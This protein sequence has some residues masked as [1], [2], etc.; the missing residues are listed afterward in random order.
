MG[1]WGWVVLGKRK[2]VR[3]GI[4]G[5]PPYYINLTMLSNFKDLV[6]DAMFLIPTIE[7]HILLLLRIEVCEHKCAAVL[8]F[9]SLL[10]VGHRSCY[11]WGGGDPRTLWPQPGT[12]EDTNL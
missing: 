12:R 2:R 6:F 11:D 5:C 1:G 3:G 4:P 10:P 9:A 7:Q 8:L